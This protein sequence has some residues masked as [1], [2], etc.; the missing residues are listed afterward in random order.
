MY[1]PEPSRMTFSSPRKVL[2]T[3][4]ASK[5]ATLALSGI[6]TALVLKLPL[7]NASLSVQTATHVRSCG[8][9]SGPISRPTSLAALPPET[10]VGR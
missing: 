5:M 2:V 8:T 3:S 6:Y 4:S 9:I 7:R 1:L 10:W